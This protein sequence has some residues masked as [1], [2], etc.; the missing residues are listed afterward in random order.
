MKEEI[1][2]GLVEKA[3]SVKQKKSV[4]ISPEAAEERRLLSAFLLDKTAE[5]TKERNERKQKIEAANIELRSGKSVSILGIRTII[6]ALMQNYPSIFPNDNPFFKNMFRLHPKL[7]G[8]DYKK[9]AK[10]RL[11]GRLLTALTYDLFEI[12]VLPAL[13][14]FAMPDGVWRTK[15]Y[16][17]L[18][19]EGIDKL[20]KF[21]N[22]ANK[23]MKK[24]EDGQWYEFYAAFCEKY[25]GQRRLFK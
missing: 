18:T 7:M 19:Q 11:A 14:V 6:T 21:R 10:P 16:K 12:E 2:K 15:C 22:Q 13:I 25:K 17:H 9:Y 23:M 5:L 4:E 24:Y 8:K 3:K 20:I 1:K